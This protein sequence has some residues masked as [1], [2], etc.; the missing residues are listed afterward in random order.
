MTEEIRVDKWLWTTRVF[1]TRSIAADA[2]KKG[3]VTIG[4]RSAKP[5]MTVKVGDVVR[6]R[7]SPITFSFKVVGITS[8]RVG[9]K[10]VENFLKNVTP[11]E[12]YQILELQQL[13]GYQGRAKGTGRP[14][15]KDRRDLDQ[16]MASDDEM[17]AWLWDDGDDPD[18]SILGADP[19]GSV[20]DEQEML[21][22]MGFWDE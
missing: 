4:N 5:A 2:C 12:E 1:K 21:D 17:K 11:P 3:R 7:K 9:P 8:N 10:L 22:S 16:F 18:D 20:D 19:C 13:S 14:T 15:K 6:V